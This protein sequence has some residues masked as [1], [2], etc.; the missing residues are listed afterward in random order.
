MAMQRREWLAAAA[1]LGVSPLALAQGGPTQG[2]TDSEILLGTHQDLTGPIQALGSHLR[3]G[4]QLAVDDIN[5]AGGVH[6]RKIR[7][8]VEDNGF[9]PKKAVLA[10]QKLVQRDKV[11]ALV[12]TLGSATTMASMNIALDANVPLLF[13]GTPADFTYTPYHRIKFGL[14]VPYGEQVRAGV[15]YA[16]DKLGKRKFGILYQDDETG[17]QVL[18]AT[19]EQLK[20]HNLALVERTSYK[21]GDINFASQIGKLKAAGCD[22]VV[23]GT[24]IRETA[25]AMQEAR[26]QGWNVDMLGNQASANS[27]VVKLGGDAMEGFYATSPALLLSAMEP[28]PA[29]TALLERFRKKYAKEPE[30]GMI[31]GYVSMMLF[32]EGARLAGKALTVDSMVAGLEKVKDWTTTLPM[33]PVTYGANDRLA[34]RSAYMLQVKGGKFV[35]ITPPITY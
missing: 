16:F 19:E 26:R 35:A 34:S 22:I 20:V 28:T 27:S 7:L 5:A 12:A 18:R 23:L 14:A 6:G 9:D 25:G 1:A 13:A 11:F 4:M 24:V 31:F 30:D 29:I 3:D 15:K 32:A 33:V 17:L 2:V 10:T 21:R 8:Q